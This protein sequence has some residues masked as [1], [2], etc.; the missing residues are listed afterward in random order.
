MTCADIDR[1]R[2]V[3]DTLLE[4]WTPQ[5]EELKEIEEIFAG[6]RENNDKL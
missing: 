2:E 4:R 5:E 3:F 6:A 1:A